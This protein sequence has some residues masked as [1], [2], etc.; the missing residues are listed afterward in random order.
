M[1]VHSKTEG[2]SQVRLTDAQHHALVEHLVEQMAGPVEEATPPGRLQGR[3]QGLL[4]DRAPDRRALVVVGLPG[5]GKTRLGPTLARRLGLPWP[6]A[7]PTLDHLWHHHPHAHRLAEEDPRTAFARCVAASLRLSID[8]K[9]ALVA[10]GLPLLLEEPPL[11]PASLLGSLRPLLL[12]GYHVS[13][14]I[15]ATGAPLA[16]LRADTRFRAAL[17]RFEA[18]EGPPPRQV[19]ERDWDGA[20]TRL[21]DMARQAQGRAFSLSGD[22]LPAHRLLI[23]DANGGLHRDTRRFPAPGITQQVR[24]LMAQAGPTAGGTDGEHEPLA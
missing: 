16:K 4:Q 13:L 5:A 6:L 9:A 14:A 12:A 8:I 1:A 15:L 23:L 22:T 11:P 10:R 7:S 21:L 20:Q 18:G 3:L 2:F 19:P 24:R 17:A